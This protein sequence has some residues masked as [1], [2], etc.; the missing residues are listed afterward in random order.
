MFRMKKMLQAVIIALM[1]CAAL[2]S[3]CTGQPQAPATEPSTD[4]SAQ[5]PKPDSGKDK[6]ATSPT[7][8]TEPPQTQPV[9]DSKIV[10]TTDVLRRQLEDQGKRFAV[11]YLGYMTYTDETVWDFLDWLHY[12]FWIQSGL[13]HP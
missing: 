1:V 10:L 4:T 9:T 2:L 11:A 8:E 3:G 7:D 5:K 12:L 6:E 13:Y